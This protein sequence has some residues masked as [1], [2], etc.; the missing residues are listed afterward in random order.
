[1]PNNKDS[2][3]L[4]TLLNELLSD[5]GLYPHTNAFFDSVSSV[6]PIHFKYREKSLLYAWLAVQNPPTQDLHS[7]FAK[8]ILDPMHPKLT[9]FV[10]WFL[11][12]YGLPKRTPSKP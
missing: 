5:S 10:S 2:G 3:T 1:M 4:E 11:E 12:L 6:E 8:R 9:A 7:A